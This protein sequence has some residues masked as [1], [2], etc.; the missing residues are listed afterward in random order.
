MRMVGYYSANFAVIRLIVYELLVLEGGPGSPSCLLGGKHMVSWGFED[1]LPVPDNSSGSGSDS[2]GERNTGLSRLRDVILT[3]LADQLQNNRFGSE[4]DEHYRLND[5]LL[6]YILKTV[7]R[8]SCILITK[9]QTVTK[10]D[11]QKLLS[12]VP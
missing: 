5:E 2:K 7:V 11:F 1:M 3:N 8:E 12:T 9:C 6:H 4:E 10:D